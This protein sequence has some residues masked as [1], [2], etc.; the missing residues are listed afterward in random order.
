ML[1]EPA[2]HEMYE[3]K[4]TIDTYD[5]VVNPTLCRLVIE[6]V[7]HAVIIDRGKP[8]ILRRCRPIWRTGE[9]PIQVL[10][11]GERY[12]LACPFCQE[13]VA[14]PHYWM[15]AALPWNNEHT[16]HYSRDCSIGTPPTF[17]AMILRLTAKDRERLALARL[18]IPPV[19]MDETDFDDDDTLDLTSRPPRRAR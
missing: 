16:L 2:V 8:A 7:G 18:R 4:R 15:V 10:T 13:R 5:D 14:I 17:E 6:R 1:G 9:R 11:Q 19:E 12:S 3:K